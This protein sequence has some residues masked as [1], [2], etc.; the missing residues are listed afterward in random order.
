MQ[1]QNFLN[2]F[3]DFF[4]L[5]HAEKIS[6]FCFVFPGRRA[7]VFF[8]KYLKEKINKPIWEPPV[9][10]I[11]D[12]FSQLSDLYSS[13]NITLLF[14]LHSCYCKVMSLNISIDEFLPFGTTI[15]NDFNDIDNY[16]VDAE[17]LFSNLYAYKMLEDDFS[18]LSDDQIDAIKTFWS[19]FDPQK[20]SQHQ[21]EFLKIWD[22]MY[23][24][25][26]M[27]KQELTSKNEAYEGMIYRI[28]AEKAKKERFVDI[29]YNHVVFAGFNALN[30]CERVI[31]NILNLQGKASYFWDYPQWL[32][33]LDNKRPP[34]HPEHEAIKFIKQNLFDFPSP[35]GWKTPAG[36]V[37]PLITIT[38]APN[39][40]VM[41]QIAAS[42][43]TD[44]NLPKND[45]EAEK[46]AVVLAD[47]NLLFPVLDSI[48]TDIESINI[49]LGYPVKNTP[50]YTLVENVLNFQKLARTTKEGKTWFYHRPLTAL[51][52]HQYIGKILG[53]SSNE[54]I[55][56]I[57]ASKQ[58]YVEKNS[59][60]LDNQASMILS[61]IDST[62]EL[63]VYFDEILTLALNS[64]SKDKNYALEFEF[65]FHIQAIVRRLADVLNEHNQHPEPDT[66]LLMFKRLA[67]QTS[68]SFK[69]EPVKGL[70]IMGIQEMRM[71]DF[72]KIIIPGMNEGIFPKTSQP[73]TFIPFNLRK[74]HGLP[75][76]ENRD[77]IFAYYFYRMINRV[78]EIN[79]VYSTTKT[80]TGE[81]EMS[82]FLQQLYYEYPGEVKI[83]HVS[84]SPKNHKPVPVYAEKD[85]NVL[86]LLQK[87]E[88]DSILSPSALSLYID[89]PLQ[90]Y[91]TY[92][93]NIRQS[94]EIVEDLDMRTFGN[95]FHQTI[96]LIYEPFVEKNVTNSDIKSLLANENEIKKC[97]NIVFEQNIPFVKQV[98]DTFI[99]LQGKNSLVYEVL[100]K[101]IKKFLELE[102]ENTP[103]KLLALE[104]R[105]SMPFKISENKTINIGGIIDRIDI[106]DNRLRI[107]D[108]K[109]G[110][111]VQQIKNIE[112]L[113]DP[114]KHFDNKA[115]FQ[116]LLY[117]CIESQTN[118]D[119][120]ITPCV[121][122]VRKLFGE[123]FA[124]D[125]ILKPDKSAGEIITYNLVKKEFNNLFNELI[126]GIFSPN[127]PFEQ[128][129]NSK[130]CKYCLFKGHCG[131]G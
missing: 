1:K 96:E 67:E 31:F 32:I 119:I 44:D 113:F 34:K 12:F 60:Q 50:A 39:D 91:F 83:E 102:I 3:T 68:V 8:K 79:L 78:N 89:C 65:V 88:K 28:V 125:I 127:I 86:K 73:D 90:F 23:E 82:R 128:T 24:L 87:W 22:K 72:D 106:K 114:K 19:S 25:Y 80:V 29:P 118:P 76:I 26:K 66:W 100:L 52:R 42:K 94:E 9:I 111:T 7:G 45:V 46:I 126:K 61:K 10:T 6:D 105:V 124:N 121:I 38:S 16:L 53:D 130:I 131:K 98:S 54:L 21:E 18:H 70:Q 109:T 56:R 59:L 5:N 108:Y 13:D 99:D 110:R 122:S 77:A 97:A 15:L 115:V 112:D 48:S 92:V 51:L 85:E 35:K 101:Y 116:T 36:N 43:I 81:G 4:V 58:I 40:L 47:E 71:L 64:L 95:L 33:D 41:A 107:I 55:K 93:A 69:G 63:T 14:R 103:F 129:E 75:T 37:L 57:I 123:N 117:A 120:E 49:T 62:N 84:Q 2:Q 27:F 30:S 11:S 20:L 104:K 74:G 17:K